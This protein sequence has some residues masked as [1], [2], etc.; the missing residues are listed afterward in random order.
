MT[1]QNI[2]Y[3]F[4]R[5]TAIEGW[6]M[7]ATLVSALGVVLFVCVRYYR[8]DVRELSR[9]IR[10]ALLSLR[11]VTVLAL[12]FFFFGLQ[13]RT[14]RLITRP[15]EVVIL[16]DTSQ[17]MSLPTADS[18]TSVPR[19]EL[20]QQIFESTDLI[21]QL[22]EQ[23]RVSVYT[24]G[25]QSAG[26]LLT[27]SGGSGIEDDPLQKSPPGSSRLA[28]LGLA[29]VGIGVIA[30]IVSL[31]IGATS[32]ANRTATA[33]TWASGTSV[34]NRS[35]MA[36]WAVLIAAFSLAIGIV[37]TGIPYATHTD[38][39]LRSLI[40]FHEP[41]HRADAS[42]SDDMD[43]DLA[44]TSPP[45]S[46]ASAKVD[47][48][49]AVAA[50]DT[51]S[52]IG[53][54]VRNVLA[55]HDPSTLAGIV[56]ISDGQ[57][58]G[59]SDPAAAVATAR[60]SEVAIYPVGLGSSN[61]PTNVRVVDLDAPR[62][63]YP[64]DR[65]SVT[66]VLQASGP[67]P[68]EVEVQLLDGL[69]KTKQTTQGDLADPLPTSTG[70]LVDSQRIKIAND[71]TLSTI[72]FEME[73]ESV[74]RR[75]LTIRVVVPPEDRN[76]LDDQR[77]AR[78][79][80]VSKKLQTLLIAGGPTREYRFARNLFFR[81]PSIELDVWL[82]TG[83]PGMSQDADKVLDSFPATPEELFEYDVII[84]F[85]P[86]W[87]TI[88]LDKI[89][90][91]DRWLAQQASG[92]I[93]IAGPVYHPQWIRKRTD[94]RTTRIAGFY[95]VNFSTH[96][97]LFSSGRLGGDTAWPLKLTPEIR[98]AEFLWVAEAPEESLQVWEDFDG[99]YDYVDAKTAKPGA[100]VYAYFS[101]PT[102]EINGNLPV[103][104]AS[105]FYGAGRVFFQASGEMWRLRAQSD[106]YFDRYFTQL[107]RWASEGRLLRDSNRGILLLDANRAM[108]GDTITVR[109]V[110]TD[111]Q[112][113][114]LDVS[115]VEGKLLAPGGQI[116]DLTLLPLEGQ[117]RPGTYG[118]RFVVRQAGSH[119]VRLTLGDGLAEQVLRQ[120]VQVRLPT[121]E[122][123]RLQR[124]DKE[125]KQYA[126]VT[127]GKYLPVDEGVTPRDVQS[128]L[129]GWLKPQPQTTVLPGTPDA[130]FNRRRNA[131][132]MWLI[133]IMLTMEWVTR[134]LHRLA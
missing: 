73:P 121:V 117:S 63:V 103:F 10:I 60:R 41:T 112:F 68:L 9:P 36:G 118:T 72:R 17:S 75:R 14:E 82:Q 48:E 132:L 114:P 69:D 128:R 108:V 87:S 130:D 27:V 55:E 7:W 100:K 18:P 57:A 101:D 105:Q 65:F 116:I 76:Q 19:D 111:E 88:P 109:A 42:I 24:F 93:L 129:V 37:L 16:V 110:L 113:E 34:L 77:D 54:A 64:G 61:S 80:V 49:N 107:A 71:G 53:D 58:N 125:L 4:E 21:D 127:G 79:E 104:M 13:R 52:R 33:T 119:E 28:Q 90:L 43:T 22:Q 12:V 85:D 3:E 62:R 78:Y 131:T 96:S 51:Q 23:H 86:D 97:S 32:R 46:N 120:S 91:L 83:Q 70:K 8:L 67:K 98:R 126:S 44:S 15:S 50:T 11:L 6:W 47:W 133:T 94:P 30:S 31:L 39:S 25:G 56:L 89:D 45:P 26:E 102:T 92:M 106:A 95:P 122:L 66:A 84:L 115:K 2:V 134:R 74:G 29:L 123:E 40:G 20:A 35:E 38:Q 99:V 59:G 1:Q 5:A 81:D 124:N